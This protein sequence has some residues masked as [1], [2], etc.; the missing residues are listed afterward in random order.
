MLEL[1]GYT[2]GHM[3]LCAELLIMENWQAVLDMSVSNAEE[4]PQ[5]TTYTGECWIYVEGC[6]ALWER[7]WAPSF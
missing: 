4:L 3:V 5:S 1:L 6:T 2:Y 7:D